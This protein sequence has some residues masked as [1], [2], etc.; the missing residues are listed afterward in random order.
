MDDVIKEDS[1]T[2]ENVNL[3]SPEVNDAQ[4]V[5]ISPEVPDAEEQK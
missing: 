2:G 1:V 4:P 5:D 3:I